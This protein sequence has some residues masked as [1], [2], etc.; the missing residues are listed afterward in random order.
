MIFSIYVSSFELYSLADI[1][2]VVNS[3]VVVD[4]IPAAPE[5]IACGAHPPAKTATT[6]PCVKYIIPRVYY[7]GEK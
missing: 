1:E 3:E 5:S 4:W 2:Q 7:N 6:F